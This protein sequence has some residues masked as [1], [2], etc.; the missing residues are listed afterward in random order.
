M[1]PN[2]IFITLDC[3][4]PDYLGCYGNSSIKTPNIDSVAKEGTLFK[5]AYSHCPLTGPAHLT[6]LTSRLPFNHGIRFNG[7]PSKNNFKKMT[8]IFKENEYQTAAFLGAFVLD[9]QF[10][11]TEGF[12]LYDD[13]MI[14]SAERLLE[15]CILA[16][17]KKR[18]L[19]IIS[20][21]ILLKETALPQK[22]KQ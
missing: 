15:I 22:I 17:D 8:Q 3:V 14:N 18:R 7:V 1:N 5:D 9:R 4:R 19:S 20:I 11:F 16:A 2:V 13:M 21:K 6:L 12:D 10:G